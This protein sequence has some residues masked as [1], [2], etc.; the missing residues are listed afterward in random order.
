[1]L[2]RF[3]FNSILSFFTQYELAR[4]RVADN[5]LKIDFT[6]KVLNLFNI[7]KRNYPTNIIL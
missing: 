2:R 7:I 4:R 1:S 3:N 6:I 5:G